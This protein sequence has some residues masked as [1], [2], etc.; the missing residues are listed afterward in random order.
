MK[1]PCDTGAVVAAAREA[2]DALSPRD[3][4]TLRAVAESLRSLQMQTLVRG[5]VQDTLRL[6]RKESFEHPDHFGDPVVQFHGE[7]S[8]ERVAHGERRGERAYDR[9]YQRYRAG[10]YEAAARGFGR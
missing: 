5:V 3:V 2:V 1:E 9:A 7:E 10:D 6:A 8:D 4:V